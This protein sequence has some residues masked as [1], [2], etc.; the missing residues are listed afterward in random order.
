[1]SLYAL[2]SLYINVRINQSSPQERY[3]YWSRDALGEGHGH[4]GKPRPNAEEDVRCGL[5]GKHGDGADPAPLGSRPREPI[6][7]HFQKNVMTLYRRPLKL[8]LLPPAPSFLLVGRNSLT[9]S[10]PP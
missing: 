8:L 6:G 9:N 4:S 2:H 10:N 7:L 5:T 1:M 3:R